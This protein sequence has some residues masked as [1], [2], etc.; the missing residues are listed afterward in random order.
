MDVTM[1]TS[2]IETKL[3]KSLDDIIKTGSGSKP[4]GGQKKGF[5]VS[6]PKARVL[7][8][9]RKPPQEGH[10]WNGAIGA[11][12][13]KGKGNIRSRLQKTDSRILSQVR[14]A[15]STFLIR[16]SQPHALMDPCCNQSLPSS[17]SDQPY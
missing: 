8:V 11:P 6:K 5:A 3:C 2:N 10:T 4:L 12:A 7:T 15:E 9:L 17:P 14:E 1:G 13:A 16:I